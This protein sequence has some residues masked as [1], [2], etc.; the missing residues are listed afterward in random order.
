MK[1]WFPYSNKL[2]ENQ[3]D[4]QVFIYDSCWVKQARRCKFILML[5]NPILI[6]ITRKRYGIYTKISL[7]IK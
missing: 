6:F 5:R 4:Y 7:K 3:K 1:N 2:E